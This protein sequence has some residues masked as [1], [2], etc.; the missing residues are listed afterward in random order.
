HG[1]WAIRSPSAAATGSSSATASARGATTVT[2]SAPRLAAAPRA[3]RAMPPGPRTTTSPGRRP[4]PTASTMPGASVLSARHRPSGSRSRVLAAPN[5]AASGVTSSATATATCFSGIVSD[6]PAHS[7]P[8][9]ATSGA[10]SS[11]PQSMAS[12]DHPSSPAAAYPARWITG[13]S[14]WATG[15]PATAARLST[16]RPASAAPQTDAVLARDPLVLLVLGVG[17]GERRLT[18]LWVDQHEEQPVALGRLQR[19]LQGRPAGAVDGPGWPPVVGVRAVPVVRVVEDLMCHLAGGHALLAAGQQPVV[20]GDVHLQPH[21]RP[22]DPVVRHPR[23]LGQ[24][25][26][27]AGLGLRD[28]R[29]DQRLVRGDAALGRHPLQELQVLG[30]DQELV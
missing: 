3:A 25:R 19:G 24:V 4:A 5:V 6:R 29:G 9:P 14:E 2:R 27:D 21:E 22:V 1:R 18:G 20:G 30:D 26:L 23:H 28:G 17:G 12:Y 11:S 13:D 15:R 10:S 7:G 16:S 8:S